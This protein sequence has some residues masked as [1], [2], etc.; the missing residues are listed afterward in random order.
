MMTLLSWLLVIA[1]ALALSYGVLLAQTGGSTGDG[2]PSWFSLAGVLAALGLAV[3]WGARKRQAQDLEERME[4]VE[5]TSGETIPRRE[6]DEKLHRIE[7]RLDARFDRIE[8]SLG[9]LF[10]QFHVERRTRERP[11]RGRD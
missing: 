4:K 2:L 3:E 5:R 1:G 9:E 6:V 8:D 7:D 11:A 10:N